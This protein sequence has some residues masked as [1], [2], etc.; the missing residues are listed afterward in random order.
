M[1][2]QPS[3]S[4][5]CCVESGLLEGLT[6]RTI[7]SLRRWGGAFSDAAVL[8]LTPRRGPRLLPS[9]LEAFKRLNVRYLYQPTNSSYSWFQYYNKPLALAAAEEMADTELVAWLDSD[10]LVVREPEALHLED[11]V[12]FAAC[13]SAKEM[14]T[15]GPG[16]PFESLWQANCGALNIDIDSLP[17]VISE[18]ERLRMRLYW[19]SGIFVYRRS[20]RLGRHFLDACTTLMNANN[21]VSHKD[22]AISFNEMG[23]VGLAMH[24]AGLKWR[25]LPYS[26]NHNI[27]K[28]SHP[29]LYR[30]D[31]FRSAA[32][33]HHHDSMLPDF[34]NTFLH[35][36][37]TTH[38]PV[39]QWLSGIGPLQ[40]K[41]PIVNRVVGKALRTFRNRKERAYISSC[42]IV[43]QVNFSSNGRTKTQK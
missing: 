37:Q 43:D 21:G 4:F 33:I 26:H 10:I 5:V 13:V 23:A 7:E 35:C 1:T 29:R 8:A 27:N 34:W 3:I 16:D 36:V 30:E 41:R 22:F 14:G 39:G 9:T 17:W 31:E 18:P 12:D 15:C 20:K 6:V 11:G 24:A 40:N 32:V 28:R 25:E 38:P 42:R 19:N 2:L